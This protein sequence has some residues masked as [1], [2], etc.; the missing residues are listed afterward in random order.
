MGGLFGY[1]LIFTGIFFVMSGN[2]INGVWFAFIG[3]FIN[4]AS[5]ASYQQMVM[6][7]IFDEIKISEFMTANVTAVDYHISVQ[8]LVDN[9]FYQFKFNSFPVKR[10]EEVIGV[11]NL[12]RA[13]N[14]PKEEW[15]QTTVGGI[16]TPLEDNLVVSPNDT[17]SKAMTK[18]FSNSIGRVLVME[19]GALT[20]IVSR[21][22]ILNYLRIHNQFNR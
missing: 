19:Q 20:G 8:E 2:I 17:V 4:Q 1:F 6:S 15:N 11:V 16:T 14:I 3:W 10:F 13:K 7:N 22:D 21:T 9:Y 18:I 5:Q 12:D